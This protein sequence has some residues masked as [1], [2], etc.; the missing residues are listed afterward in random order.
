MMMGTEQAKYECYNS[1]IDNKEPY[2]DHFQKT[3][4]F[5]KSF[6]KHSSSQISSDD[7]VWTNTSLIE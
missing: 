1:L 7:A 4:S 3:S 5:A 6:R 2:K